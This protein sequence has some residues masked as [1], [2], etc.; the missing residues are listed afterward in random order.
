MPHSSPA[1]RKR[2]SHSSRPSRGRNRPPQR[3]RIPAT[4]LALLA[5]A[6]AIGSIATGAYF[7]FHDDVFAGLVGRQAER[8]VHYEAQ[9]ADLR[10][11]I[12]RIKRLDQER[13]EEQVKTML[14]R[15]ATLDQVTPGLANEL[16]VQA[17]NG[18]PASGALDS[19]P[20]LAPVEK[21]SSPNVA[22]LEEKEVKQVTIGHKKAHRPHR[23][24]ARVFRKRTRKPPTIAAGGPSVYA[25]SAGQRDY[26][27]YRDY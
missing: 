6:L 17:R 3:S 4:R 2:P 1:T 13:V 18:L 15:Q 8:Q 14:Q 16:S 7:A 22:V 20:L 11:Q 23:K 25:G 21:P 10:A 19:P 24:Y 5:S 12:D 26:R 9:I 27:D